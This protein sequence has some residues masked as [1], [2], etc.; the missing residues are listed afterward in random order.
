[1]LELVRAVAFLVLWTT[2]ARGEPPP[3]VRLVY[4]RA[5]G[6]EA[7]PDET[8][9]RSAVIERLHYDPFQ[10]DALRSLATS[11]EVV[12]GM[13]VGTLRLEGVGG[14]PLAE[15]R[16]SADTCAALAD[17]MTL[18]IAIADDLAPALAV[19]GGTVRAGL[20]MPPEPPPPKVSHG[21]PEPEPEPEGTE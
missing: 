11:I 13:F 3:P 21:E 9:L 5:A 8:A 15:K 19:I 4:E 6:T 16:L 12:E 1:M 7:C 18:A 17:A 2:V 20:E 14:Q 10:E